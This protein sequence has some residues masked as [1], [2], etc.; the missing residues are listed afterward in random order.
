VPLFLLRGIGVRR[1]NL[2]VKGNVDLRDSLLYSRVGG[3][4]AWNGINEVVRRQFPGSVVRIRHE[5]WTRSDALLAAGDVV[6]LELLARR[7]PLGPYPAESQFSRALFTSSA[8]AVVLSIQPDVMGRLYRHRR[9]G[10]L[11]YPSWLESWSLGDRQWLRE[12]FEDVG[13]LGARASMDNFARIC[14]ELRG[15]PDVPILVYNLSAVVPGEQVHCYEGLGEVL[16][17][18]IR[19]FNLALV[20]LSERT[21]ISVVDVDAVL[22]RA[23][24]DRLK[25]DAIHLT[26]EGYRLV[27]EEVVRI[28]EDLGCFDGAG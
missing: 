24:A 9:D 19:R 7:L 10:Y 20:E 14:E 25:V 5:T 16:A 22:A 1:L 13:L 6:P 27:A 21:G 3:T 18:R 23:G 4:V 11:L 15:R 26:A 8:D 17:T 2:F 12:N 28:L